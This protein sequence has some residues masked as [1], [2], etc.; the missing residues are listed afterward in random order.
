M[1]D[2]NLI[3]KYSHQYYVAELKS[4]YCASG[5]LLPRTISHFTFMD[6]PDE[7]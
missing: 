6:S 7:V 5:S 2:T 4:V 1:I 3:L